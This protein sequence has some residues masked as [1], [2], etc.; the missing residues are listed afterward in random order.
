MA[1]SASTTEPNVK[2]VAFR[3][4]LAVLADQHGDAIVEKVLADAG[5]E[6]GETLRYRIVQTG[7][8]PISLYRALWASILRCTGGDYDVVRRIG[9]GAIRRDVT[10]V[11]RMIF[12][13]L[14]PETVL[15]LS[16]KLFGNYYD[17]GTLTVV[18]RKH[19]SARAVYEGCKGFD[20]A[21]WEELV[22]SALELIAIG[23]GKN[24]RVAIEKG[25]GSAPHCVAFIEWD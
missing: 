6:V 23:G 17:T 24:V 15:G 25:G 7:W 9:A 3:S 1:S 4:V 13:V 18:D 19:G 8:Y 11:Y 22:G 20:R 21:M 16:G 12:K 10:G 14:S 2:G 5:P